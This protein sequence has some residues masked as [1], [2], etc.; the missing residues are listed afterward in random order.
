[1][2]EPDMNTD[3]KKITF[4]VN[5]KSGT[6]D[7]TQIAALITECLNH[8][9]Y[10]YQIVHTQY[11]GHA[12]EIAAECAS[13]GHHAVVAVGGDGT[14]NEVGRSLV[15]TGTALGIIPCGSGNGLARHL[16]IP[17][18]ARKAIDVLNEGY[19]ETIDYGRSLQTR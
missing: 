2:P 19:I 12:A 16:H 5:P 10:N 7:K 14:I 3:K 18:N 11:A 13:A 15:H 17:L 6:Q 1:M 8:D 9:N 4:V